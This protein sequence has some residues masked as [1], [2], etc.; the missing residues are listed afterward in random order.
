MR[1]RDNLA[2]V[3]AAGDFDFDVLYLYKSESQF[4]W[5]KREAPD[6][7]GLFQVEDPLGSYDGLLQIR[8]LF[9]KLQ[10]CPYG[11]ADPSAFVASLNLNHA[12]QQDSLDSQECFKLL[13]S[14]LEN[15]LRQSS[16]QMQHPALLQ[17]PGTCSGDVA[18]GGRFAGRQ[19]VQV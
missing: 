8:E 16:L 3:Q 1:T 4:C 19:S 9:A 6:T 10:S 15:R 18:R 5:S 13:L 17:Y 11:S 2:A 14:M 7:P 12:I